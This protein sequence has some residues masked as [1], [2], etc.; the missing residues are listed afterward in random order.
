M[1]WKNSTSKEIILQNMSYCKQSYKFWVHTIQLMKKGSVNTWDWPWFF[2]IATQGQYNIF[3]CSNLVSNIGFGEDATHTFGLPKKAYTIKSE[4]ALPLTHP[5]YV[6]PD[7]FFD[8]EY[9]KEEIIKRIPKNVY[10]YVPKQLKSILKKL[11][12]FK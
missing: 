10:K 4:I 12:L 9:E 11:R 1:D 6:V 7:V 8:I 2:S 5:T 3:P